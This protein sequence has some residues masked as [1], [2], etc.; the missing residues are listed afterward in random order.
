[1]IILDDNSTT[2]TKSATSTDTK[3][4]I[5]LDSLQSAVDSL[6]TQI[7]AINTTLSTLSNSIDDKYSAQTQTLLTALTNQIDSLSVALEASISTA[8]LNATYGNFSKLTATLSATMTELTAS[9]AKVTEKLTVKE[10]EI[11]TLNADLA[12]I[13]TLNAN[14]ANLE[15]A[16][17]NL[18]SVVSFAV[19]TLTA[20]IIN[21]DD[22]NADNASISSIKSDKINTKVLAG[23]AWKT[24]IST[25]DNTE[26][27]HI[28]IPKYKGIIQLQTEDV[29][30]N[31]TIFNDSSI[32][33]NQQDYFIYRV[34]R[35]DNTFDIYLKNVGDTVNYRI[36]HVGSE[37]FDS[38]SSEIVDRTLYQQNIDQLHDVIFFETQGKIVKSNELGY[39]F[40]LTANI[41]EQLDT[42]QPKILEKPVEMLGN[43]YYSVETLLEQISTMLVS[44]LEDDIVYREDI[45][46]LTF[47]YSSITYNSDT[48]SITITGFRIDFIDGVLYITKID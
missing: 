35:N 12:D 16:N 21:A 10:S 17:I 2:E 22:V 37:S 13:E 46:A 26:L 20:T 36:L 4:D 11:E 48:E 3:Q 5:K 47:P 34:E 14:T 23:K 39:L 44:M 28:S 41:Q 43:T 31:L 15:T 33:L 1:M 42:K 29:E 25:P 40:G 27:L 19:N 8:Q 45:E 9:V 38:E 30:F 7:S 24:P 6:N 18:L 32:T